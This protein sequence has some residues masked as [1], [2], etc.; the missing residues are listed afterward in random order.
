MKNE[1]VTLYSPN[2]LHSEYLDAGGAAWTSYDASSDDEPLT[3]EVCE[4][5]GLT[6]K[7]WQGF[8]CLDGGDTICAD[9][10]EIVPAWLGLALAAE[11]TETISLHNRIVSMRCEIG[12]GVIGS[13]N[14]RHKPGK[15]LGWAE[16]IS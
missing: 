13:F 12:L 1:T 6:D 4:S 3:C 8:L 5:A 9:H 15:F 10:V 14:A 7:T 2:D 11:F 16:P